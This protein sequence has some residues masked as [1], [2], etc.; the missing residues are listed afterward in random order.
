MLPTLP[1]LARPSLTTGWSPFDAEGYHVLDIPLA[2]EGLTIR[3][4]SERQSSLLVLRS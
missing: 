1:N 2:T 4:V 3:G